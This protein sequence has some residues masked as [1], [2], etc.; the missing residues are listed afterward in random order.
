MATMDDGTPRLHE[1]LAE[2]ESQLIRAYLAGT[3]HQLEELLARRDDHARTLL[4]AASHY[5]SQR[6]SEVEARSHYIHALH[7]HE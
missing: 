4:A 1:P 7:G 2:L 3:G 5:A 6:L